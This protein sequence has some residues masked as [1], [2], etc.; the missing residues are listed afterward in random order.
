MADGSNPHRCAVPPSPEV[1]NIE[2]TIKCDGPSSWL[3]KQL[4]SQRSAE[5]LPVS[6]DITLDDTPGKREDLFALSF[7]YGQPSPFHPPGA[8]QVRVR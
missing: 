4:G 8:C 2:W 5:W 6:G 1:E 7:V 3:R